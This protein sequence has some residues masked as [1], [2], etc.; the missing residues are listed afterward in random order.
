M[1]RVLGLIFLFVILTLFEAT[2]CSLKPCTVKLDD[3]EIE[4]LMTQEPAQ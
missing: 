3:A 2:A 4:Q 1:K